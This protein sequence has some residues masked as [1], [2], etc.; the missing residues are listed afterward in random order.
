M[1]GPWSA[2]SPGGRKGGHQE[3]GRP[4]AKGRI[5]HRERSPV[6]GAGE[7][8]TQIA[9]GFDSKR[10]GF[11]PLATVYHQTA[12]GRGFHVGVQAAKCHAGVTIQA[13]RRA[14][15]GG[16]Y[17]RLSRAGLDGDGDLRGRRAAA[18]LRAGRAGDAQA[19]CAGTERR[20]GD[21]LPCR[22][23]GRRLQVGRHAPVWGQGQ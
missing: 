8:G 16:G 19:H 1:V 9:P 23:G 22:A 3:C 12:Y 18:E 21:D 20:L 10:P 15:R 5:Q 6:H 11:D 17:G 14:R 7:A 4:G 2:R 13:C